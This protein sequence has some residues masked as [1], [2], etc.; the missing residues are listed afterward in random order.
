MMPAG[1]TTPPITTSLVDTMLALSRQVT[2]TAAHA[3]NRQ[4]SVSENG[5]SAEGTRARYRRE[6]SPSKPTPCAGGILLSFA[7]GGGFLRTGCGPGP[8]EPDLDNPSEGNT[9]SR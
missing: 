5:T 4:L 7:V 6:K 9:V 2:K 1:R 3:T 8:L